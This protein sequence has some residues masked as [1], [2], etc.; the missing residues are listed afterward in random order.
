MWLGHEQH[1]CSHNNENN[2]NSFNQKLWYDCIGQK[3]KREECMC[4]SVSECE[5][6]MFVCVCVCTRAHKKER[7][8]LQ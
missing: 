1:L 5:M 4:M 6:Y 8:Q 3:K 7:F 2:E